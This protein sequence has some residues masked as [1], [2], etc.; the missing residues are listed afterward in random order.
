MTMWHHDREPANQKS[1]KIETQKLVFFMFLNKKVFC[2]HWNFDVVFE[3][4]KERKKKC[5]YESIREMCD[6][7]S[8]ANQQCD[9][10]MKKRWL[11]GRRKANRRD[12]SKGEKIWSWK[13]ELLEERWNKLW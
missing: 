2:L 12:V 9:T 3:R 7:R 1:S 8:V 5:C 4:N 13:M 6:E 10:E 11:G